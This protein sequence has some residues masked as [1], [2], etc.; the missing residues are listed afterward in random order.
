LQQLVVL[1]VQKLHYNFKEVIFL[2]NSV[3][4]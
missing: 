1:K 2:N 3:D 4:C